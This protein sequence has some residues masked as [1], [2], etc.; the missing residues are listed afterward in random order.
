MDM[1]AQEAVVGRQSLKR[2]VDETGADP[3]VIHA[4][5]TVVP[6]CAVTERATV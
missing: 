4:E 1:K 6:D 2:Q 5:R 3:R